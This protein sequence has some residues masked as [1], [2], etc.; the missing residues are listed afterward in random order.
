MMNRIILSSIVAG[1][2]A[3]SAAAQ[4][5][6]YGVTVNAE[7]N[8]DFAAI[9]TYSWTKGQPSAIK[10]VDAQIVAAVD[11]ELAALGLTKAASGPGDVLLAYYSLTRTDVDLK[12]KPDAQGARPEYKVGTLMVALLDPGT[13]NRLLRLRTDKPIDTEPAKLETAINAAVSELFASYPTR[14]AKK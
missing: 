8:V 6:K 1:A 4:Q 5:P 13:R 3:V 14:T 12:A 2:L 10:T 9:K 7:K 11:R